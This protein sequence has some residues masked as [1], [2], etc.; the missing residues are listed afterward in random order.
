MA[1]KDKMGMLRADAIGVEECVFPKNIGHGVIESI[2]LSLGILLATDQELGQHPSF[3]LRS[4]TGPNNTKAVN[5]K[6]ETG[7]D[8]NG[9]SSK[10]MRRASRIIPSTPTN[11]PDPPKCL[12]FRQVNWITLDKEKLHG[13]RLSDPTP[14]NFYVKH[15]IEDRGSLVGRCTRVWC[16]YQE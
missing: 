6:H 10:K 11:S 9:R 12:T 2:R 5:K 3:F 16:V 4:V 13:H 7:E 14:T 8:D 15:L 1:T